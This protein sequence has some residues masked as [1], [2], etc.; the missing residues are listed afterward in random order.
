VSAVITVELPRGLCHL[1]GAPNEIQVAVDGAITQ[2]TILDAVEQRYPML[3]GTIRDHTTRVRRPF[4]RFFLAGQDLSHLGPD[5]PLPGERA[6]ANG[7]EPFLIIGAI[8][9]G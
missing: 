4:I 6:L 5:D 8:A 9:G 7:T 1:S 2:R 3:E